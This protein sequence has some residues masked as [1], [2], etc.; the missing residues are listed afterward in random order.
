MPS[1]RLPSGWFSQGRAKPMQQVPRPRPCAASIKFCAAHCAILGCLLLGRCGADHHRR[2]RAMQYVAGGILEHAAKAEVR[3]SR[4]HEGQR[5]S[6]AAVAM[7]RV[8]CRRWATAIAMVAGL[9]MSGARTAASI[10]FIRTSGFTGIAMKQ[11]MA[12]R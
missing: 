12:R 8:V 5:R 3:R 7:L 9:I 10:K 4:L 2:G 1:K 11:R 6:L